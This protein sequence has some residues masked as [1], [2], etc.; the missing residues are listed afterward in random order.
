MHFLASRNS[1]FRV[2][3]ASCKFRGSAALADVG[4]VAPAILITSGGVRECKVLRLPSHGAA[5]ADVIPG[6][7]LFFHILAPFS[8]SFGQLAIQVF[9]STLLFSKPLGLGF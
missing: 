7:D 2:V 1:D 8:E 5:A 6:G 4:I 9:S 3:A